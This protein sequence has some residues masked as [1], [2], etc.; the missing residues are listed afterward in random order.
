MGLAVSYIRFSRPEQ[1]KGDSLRRQTARYLALCEKHGWTPAGENNYQDLGVSGYKGKHRT[2]GDFGKFLRAVE[3]G[4][5]PAGSVL[6]V[7]M[8]DRLSREEPLDVVGIISKILKAG[9]LIA[10]TSPERI[11]DKKSANEIG[12]LLEIVVGV[13]LAHE[14]SRKKGE[15]VAARWAEKKRLARE[16]KKPM[17]YIVPLWLRTIGGPKEQ[18]KIEVIAERAKLVQEMFRLAA[19]GM[20]GVQ[21][22]RK[23]NKERVATWGRRKDSSPVWE[24]SYIRKILRNRAVLGEYN[25][26][27]DY[28]PRVIHTGLWN[29]A[30]KAMNSRYRERGKQGQVAANLF[31]GLVFDAHDDSPMVI[32]SCTRKCGNGT[33]KYRSIVS[34]SA[35]RGVNG[36][37]YMTYSYA[38]FEA[39]ILAHLSEI[40]PADFAPQTY[41]KEHDELTRLEGEEAKIA[42]RI[43]EIRNRMADSDESIESLSIAAATLE[44]KQRK[45][46]A[47]IEVVKQTLATPEKQTWRECQNLIE[48]LNNTPTDEIAELRQALRY[49]IKDLISKIVVKIEAVGYR[50]RQARSEVIYRNGKTKTVL[51]TV[52]PYFGTSR[53]A[54]QRGYFWIA[55][56]LRKTLADAF[57]HLAVK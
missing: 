7:E 31:S 54:G 40:A 16:E 13:A 35:Q 18:R 25:G 33:T 24:N 55:D 2:K 47:H 37:K 23:F 43:T 56:T 45:L 11:Y 30:Q 1:L 36:S 51:I 50:Q 15:R 3:E 42:N 27:R 44:S 10:T 17:T 5:I 34:R 26:I 9:I 29:R 32:T 22:C 20:G 53:Q 6:V 38:A 14:E 41:R 52:D 19:S 48:L 12:P 39:G 46:A 21:I 28:F 57:P 8:V 4:K 49:R